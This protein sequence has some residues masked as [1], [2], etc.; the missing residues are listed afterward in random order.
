VIAGPSP[1]Q[2]R[3][4]SLVRERERSAGRAAATVVAGRVVTRVTDRGPT[5]L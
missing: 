1:H 2:P 3:G 4:S 5:R